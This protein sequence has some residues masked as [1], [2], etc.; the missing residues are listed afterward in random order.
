MHDS[1]CIIV[2][3]PAA[4]GMRRKA[5]R[6]RIVRLAADLG[7]P[8]IGLE[9]RSAEEWRHCVAEV[10]PY[11]GVLVVAGGDGT[12]A[13]ALNAKR[14]DPVLAFFPAGSGN[15]L[16]WA[17][18]QIGAEPL[19]AATIRRQRTRSVGVVMCNGVRK[20][21][22]ASI[23]LDALAAYNYQV[24]SRTCRSGLVRY[25]SALLAAVRAYRSPD[26]VMHGGGQ[27]LSLQRCLT[28]IVSKQPFYGYGLR[29]NSGRLDD[30]SLS[31]RSLSGP[32]IRLMLPL[33]AAACRL[34]P[35]H[36]RTGTRYVIQSS[37]DLWMQCDGEAVCQGREFTFE[38]LADHVRMLL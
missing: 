34:P 9:C 16:R 7:C 29:V 11:T 37:H 30:G 1:E 14:G 27:Q 20:A 10:S 22:S 2:A 24:S 17:L 36:S 4:G 38:L 12:F 3:N 21:F 23:G 5:G 8:L 18:R 13:D 33:M 6:N 32:A 15:A 19:S 35:S 28:V 25:T 26:V 31:L